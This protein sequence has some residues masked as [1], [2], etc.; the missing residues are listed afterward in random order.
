MR[1][2]RRISFFLIWVLDYDDHT[3][4]LPPTLDKL[5]LKKLP[6]SIPTAVDNNVSH[7]PSYTSCLISGCLVSRSLLLVAC[8][9]SHVHAISTSS[10]A[11]TQVPLTMSSI[12]ILFPHLQFHHLSIHRFPF[13]PLHLPPI[14]STLQKMNRVYSR[15]I[16]KARLLV[17]GT[18]A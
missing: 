11:S 1:V 5:S 12:S 15:S 16:L 10:L 8:Y 3:K 18:H 6:S 13:I 14:C 2:F 17:H 4:P 7:R 9:T